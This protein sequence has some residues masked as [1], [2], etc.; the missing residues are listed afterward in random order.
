MVATGAAAGTSTVTS[1]AAAGDGVWGPLAGTSAVGA[2]GSTRSA[3]ASTVAASG[4]RVGGTTS[5]RSPGWSVGSLIA[6]ALE[7][8]RGGKVACE[9]GTIMAGRGYGA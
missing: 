9:V 3:E 5:V 6:H 7:T 8:S 1:G 4:P 2:N